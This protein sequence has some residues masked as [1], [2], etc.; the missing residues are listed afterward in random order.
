MLSNEIRAQKFV[1][2]QRLFRFACDLWTAGEYSRCTDLSSEL[3]GYGDAF[4]ELDS[5]VFSYSLHL[6]VLLADFVRSGCDTFDAYA[7]LKACEAFSGLKID[8]MNTTE[9]MTLAAQVR[10][11]RGYRG[12]YVVLLNGECSGWIKQLTHLFTW[13]PGSIAVDQFGNQY[14]SVKSQ[15]LSSPIR[16]DR[17]A[18]SEQVQGVA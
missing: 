14:Q 2:L 4:L 10:A 11:Y 16:W 15:S 12:G 13:E 8:P 3:K 1:E 17:I 18:T 9:N 7:M 6:S 5:K